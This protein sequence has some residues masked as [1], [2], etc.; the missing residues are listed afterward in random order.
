MQPFARGLAGDLQAVTVIAHGAHAGA[1]DD[2]PLLRDVVHRRRVAGLRLAL[3][4]DGVALEA[5]GRLAGA[6]GGQGVGAAVLRLLLEPVGPRAP[7]VLGVEGRALL[8]ELLVDRLDFAA[9]RLARLGV[10]QLLIR[11]ALAN[12]L[13]RCAAQAVRPLGR[14]DQPILAMPGALQGLTARRGQG[15]LLGLVLRVQLH[16]VDAETDGVFAVLPLRGGLRLPFGRS[17]E[18]A[19]PRLQARLGK[20]AGYCARLHHRSVAGLEHEA[21]GADAQLQAVVAHDLVQL[22]PGLR[23]LD[24][25]QALALDPADQ[26][27]NAGM[28]L[29]VGGPALRAA[30]ARLVVVALQAVVA[31]QGRA[32]F[33]QRPVRVVRLVHR[34]PRRVNLVDGDVDVQVVGVV[35]DGTD[36]LM[37]A[38]TQPDADAFLNRAQG[39]GAGLLAGP[40]AD[41]QVVGLVALRAGVRVLGRQHLRDGVLDGTGFAVRRLHVAQPVVFALGVGD[42]VRQAREVAL[43]KRAHRHVLG[44]HGRPSGFLAAKEVKARPS[45]EPRPS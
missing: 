13:D 25:V 18:R 27:F 43:A 26:A 19:K 17:L 2:R 34:V 30:L 28:P 36:S 4:P 42:V 35:V 33:R 7:A 8:L 12:H 3:A 29:H 39:V 21:I 45:A 31:L 44:D 32:E 6:Q 23:A 38:I 40:E 1:E 14:L 10:Q 9:Q 5:L 24:L 11:A 20:V 41:D 37:L 22:L 15:L 16:G